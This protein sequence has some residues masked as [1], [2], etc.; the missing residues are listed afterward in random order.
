MLLLSRLDKLGYG[1]GY[2]GTTAAAPVFDLTNRS[3]QIQPISSE[4]KHRYPAA[5]RLKRSIICHVG[6]TNSG[7]TY[8]AL[9][10]LRGAANGVYCGPL[11][12][13]AWEVHEKLNA[14]GVVRWWF[15][16]L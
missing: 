13:L 3:G 14:A 2:G 10:R 11:R 5:R 16:L 9:E 12:L 7:K 8:E 4:S 1:V 6:P 15:L